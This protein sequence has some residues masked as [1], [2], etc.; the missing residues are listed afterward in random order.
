ME[1][2]EKK[3]ENLYSELLVVG[4]QLSP[5]DTLLDAGGTKTY[6]TGLAHFHPELLVH[7]IPTYRNLHL[8]SFSLPFVVHIPLS[9]G[10]D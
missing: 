10:S 3:L 5:G 8:D 4:R 7:L 1:F 9:L 6:Q 2:H